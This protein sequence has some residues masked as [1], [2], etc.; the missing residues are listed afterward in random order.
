MRRRHELP[1]YLSDLWRRVMRYGEAPPAVTALAPLPKFN[2]E[3]GFNTHVCV[4]F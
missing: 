4:D 1:R 3:A 2:F